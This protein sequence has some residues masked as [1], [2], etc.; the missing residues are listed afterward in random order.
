MRLPVFKGLSPRV[1][2]DVAQLMERRTYQVGSFIFQQGDEAECLYVLTAGAVRIVRQMTVPR[3]FAAKH[4]T[5]IPPPPTS[6]Y[7]NP[8]IFFHP[9]NLSSVCL[10][11]CSVLEKFGL[12]TFVSALKHMSTHATCSGPHHSPDVR[13]HM[14]S[15][16]ALSA[17]PRARHQE[18]EAPLIPAPE[19]Q[20]PRPPPAAWPP[21]QQAPKCCDCSSRHPR[22]P[23]K[24]LSA[25]SGCL[26]SAEAAQTVH[27]RTANE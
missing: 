1:L 22:C 5:V 3:S 8:Y 12:Y 11:S 16:R 25:A 4:K 26:E 24:Q 21:S 20:R 19:S 27:V 6:H 9:K 18:R 15:G 14:C 7:V 13:P 17:Y 23:S 2:R 10:G